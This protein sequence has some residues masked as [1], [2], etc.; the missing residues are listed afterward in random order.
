MKLKYLSLLTLIFLIGIVSAQSL[1]ITDIN[2]SSTTVNHDSTVTGTINVTATGKNF[3]EINLKTAQRPADIGDIKFS[4]I[5]FTPKTLSLDASQSHKSQIVSY[6]ITIP[7]YTPA[8]QYVYKFNAVE[9]VTAGTPI[10]SPDSSITITVNS[11]PSLSLSL[12][13]PISQSNKNA[14]LTVKNDGNV[15]L[16][17]I[18]LSYDTSALKDRLGREI[19]LSFLDKDNKPIQKFT[20]QPGSSQ[21]VKL[22]ADFPS[23]LNPGD[24]KTTIKA[25]TTGF[26]KSTD[27]TIKQGF[28]D[29]GRIGSEMEIIR[30]K[31]LSSE[32]EFKWKPGDDVEIEVKVRNNGEDDED[33]TVQLELYDP[34]NQQIVDI[35]NDEESMSIDN[36][37]SETVTFKISVPKDIED[38]NHRLYVKAFVDG[39]EDVQCT[40]LIDNSDFRSIDIDKKSHDVKI[41]RI[42]I[43]ESVS[44]GGILDISARLSNIGDKDEDRVVLNVGNRQLGIDKTSLP[45]SLD[46]GNDR[47]T[48]FSI[49]IPKDKEDG[50]Y[51]LDFSTLFNYDDNDDVYKSESDIEKKDIEL[52]DCKKTE[53]SASI[54]AE[55]TSDALAGE[56]MTVKA[57]IV[58]TGD[59][60]ATYT[61]SAEGYEDWATLSKIEPQVL[62]IQKGS[63][64]TA[65]IYLNIDKSTSGDKE[66]RIVATSDGATQSQRVLIQNIAG[67]SSNITGAAIS[68]SFRNNWFIWLIV[69][70]NI[71]LI[72]LIIIA[73]RR[74]V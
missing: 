57:T 50:R 45:V 9:I 47:T 63:S 32:D 65:L 48:Q 72:V 58:N 42:I 1:T 41:D 43:P 27:L 40:D 70:I 34:V 37:K 36:G 74:L 17:D 15:V 46:S 44:C 35:D 30:V 64:S 6:S 23:S 3:A 69:L 66:F 4:D 49:L 25:S 13:T 12:S 52:V 33:V 21:E 24:Y 38:H 55:L 18:S 11:T 51:T 39:D 56:Q 61:L 29:S 22:V 59:A 20:L 5:S 26:D 53:A 31:D 54:S 7:K 8:G 73:A 10:K 14:T 67:G 62:T 60:A 19:K 71:V 16:T 28:C 68:A 2:P